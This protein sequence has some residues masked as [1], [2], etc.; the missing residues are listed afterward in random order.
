MTPH[1]NLAGCWRSSEDL[2]KRCLPI[3]RSN[4]YSCCRSTILSNVRT[5]LDS[6]AVRN[7]YSEIQKNSF[8]SSRMV[9]S[10]LVTACPIV[11]GSA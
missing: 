1:V 8:F 3:R 10:G 5:V 7:T 4:V 9:S 2:R 6:N 11:R